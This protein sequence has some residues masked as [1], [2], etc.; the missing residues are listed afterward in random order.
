M[1]VASILSLFLKTKIHLIGLMWILNQNFAFGC[2]K[3]QKR[4]KKSNISANPKFGDKQILNRGYRAMPLHTLFAVASSLA[5]KNS[6]V[7]I[8]RFIFR[9][10]GIKKLPLRVRQF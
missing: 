5:T 8:Q 3:L 1:F 7:K 4:I 10:G 2:S 9:W 6:G